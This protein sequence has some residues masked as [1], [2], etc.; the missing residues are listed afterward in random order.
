[1][2]YRIMSNYSDAV[3]INSNFRGIKL[4]QRTLIPAASEQIYSDNIITQIN[5]KDQTG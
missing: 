3:G 4:L 2:N 5:I 1:M